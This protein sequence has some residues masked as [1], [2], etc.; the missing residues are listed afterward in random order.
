MSRIRLLLLLYVLFIG[1]MPS[2]AEDSSPGN[3]RYPEV[4]IPNTETIPMSSTQTG[5]DYQIFVELPEDYA[6]ADE[7]IRYSVVYLLDA[8][9]FFGAVTDF[10][11][12][13]NLVEEMPSVIVVCIGYPEKPLEGRVADMLQNPDKFLEFIGDE[14]IPFIDNTYRTKTSPSDRAFVGHSLGGQF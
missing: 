12:L 7:D 10:I 4:T 3:T 9:Y 13:E 11:R 14:L 8:N 6:S 1:A 2:N 5:R